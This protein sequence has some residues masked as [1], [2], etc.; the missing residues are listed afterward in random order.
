[1]GRTAEAA[2][3]VKELPRLYPA[4]NL[5]I[6]ADEMRIWNFPESHIAHRVD[7]LRKAGVPDAP[8]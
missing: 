5:K 8:S 6:A 2:Q 1:M 7:G 4:F 3:S